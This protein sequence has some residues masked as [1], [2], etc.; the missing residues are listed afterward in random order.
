MTR[1]KKFLFSILILVIAFAAYIFFGQSLI[2]FV[3]KRFDSSSRQM[4]GLKEL[5]PKFVITPTLGSLRDV[6][7]AKGTVAYN[8]QA[9]IRSHI[10]GQV[11]ALTAHEGNEVT[12][13]QQ[14]IRIS[15]PQEE[16]DLDLRKIELQ[17]GQD[18]LAA[19]NKDV[20]AMQRLITVGAISQFELDQK[21]LDRNITEKDIEKVRL[22]LARIKQTVALTNFVSP[23]KG[24]VLSVSVENG[25]RVNV[26]DELISLSGGNGPYVQAHIDAMDLERVHI[27]QMAIFSNQEDGGKRRKGRV[28]EISRSV[29]TAQRPNTVKVII[30]PQES[31]RDLRLSQQLY[32]ELVI[33]EE[34]SVIR[35]PREF[36]YKENGREVV[37]VLSDKGIIAKTI[38]TQPGDI[39]FLKLKSG[40][41][42]TDRLV[43]KPLNTGNGS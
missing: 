10:N 22:E 15:H 38:Q 35:I 3:T 41:E 31:I 4:I 30:E 11:T 37:Y 14:L 27:G 12:L 28:K 43:R 21:I 26:G 33:L 18:N 25:Q 6:I 9:I 24:L 7:I 42:Q 32:V 40:L 23:V 16:I 17:R 5:N 29:A 39:S 36:V 20:A 34:D 13:G 2:D 8:R 1:S 19:L